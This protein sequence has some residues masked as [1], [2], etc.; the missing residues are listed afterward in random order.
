M[1]FC[2]LKEQSVLFPVN[3]VLASLQPAGILSILPNLRLNCFFTV[4]LKGKYVLLLLNLPRN[5][6]TLYWFKGATVVNRHELA[7][8]AIATNQRVLGPA[9]SGRETMYTNDMGT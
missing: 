1:N 7:Q 4:Q 5:V 2:P 9:H 6:Q 3:Q 8:F